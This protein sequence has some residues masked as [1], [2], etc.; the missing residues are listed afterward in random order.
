VKEHPYRESA[1]DLVPVPQ[2]RKM[3][4]EE[5]VFHGLKDL[6]IKRV[7]RADDDTGEACYLLDDVNVAVWENGQVLYGSTKVVSKSAGKKLFAIFAAR[8]PPPERRKKNAPI[9]ELLDKLVDLNR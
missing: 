5:Q 1:K 8:Q 4:Q 9:V 2:K 6:P 3:S 7:W